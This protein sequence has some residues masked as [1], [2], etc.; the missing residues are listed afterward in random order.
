MRT[1]L[2]VQML[3]LLLLCFELLSPHDVAPV[4][5]FHRVSAVLDVL[6]SIFASSHSPPSM[7]GQSVVCSESMHPTSI[8]DVEKR[9]VR[10][11]A[12]D[13]PSWLMSLHHHQKTNQWPYAQPTL[14]SDRVSMRRSGS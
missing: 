6:L 3:L 8:H 14:T 9:F 7:Y 4:C 10:R 5:L 1:M 2:M 12:V 11:D 13:Q